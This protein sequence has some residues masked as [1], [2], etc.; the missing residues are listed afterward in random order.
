MNWT[1]IENLATGERVASARIKLVDWN[2]I[3]TALRASS[4][5]EDRALGRYLEV[6]IVEPYERTIVKQEAA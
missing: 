2:R 5:V 4:D 6:A 1:R 3:V